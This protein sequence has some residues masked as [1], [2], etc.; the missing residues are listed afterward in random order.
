M[1]AQI[2][3][4]VYLDGSPASA[5]M[6]ALDATS[7]ELVGDVTSNV[8]TGAYEFPFGAA[9]TWDDDLVFLWEGDIS[10]NINL[11]HPTATVSVTGTPVDGATGP[12]G[13]KSVYFPISAY[14]ELELPVGADRLASGQSWTVEAC[15]RFRG[16]SG[17]QYDDP[18]IVTTTGGAT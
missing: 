4:N 18:I 7:G 14:Q 5:R 16:Y 2:A 17:T 6:L 12:Y 8:V 1:A 11:I 10:N 13:G 9:S 3:G 15:L